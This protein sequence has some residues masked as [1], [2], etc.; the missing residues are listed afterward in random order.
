MEA[1]LADNISS[2]YIRKRTY[3]TYHEKYS[4]GVNLR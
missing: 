1:L 2:E 4:E 3:D